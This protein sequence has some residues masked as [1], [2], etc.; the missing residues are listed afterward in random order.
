MVKT[1]EIL[2]PE[3][4]RQLY[5]GD[6]GKPNENEI[7]AKS[8]EVYIVMERCDN[9]LID[10]DHYDMQSTRGQHFVRWMFY[11]LLLGVQYMHSRGKFQLSFMRSE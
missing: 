6:D 11:Q 9:K 7:V 2:V 3:A 8:N 5:D 10:L 1:A 4:M